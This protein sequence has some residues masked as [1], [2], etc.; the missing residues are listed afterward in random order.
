MRVTDRNAVCA[1]E[2]VNL[3]SDCKIMKQRENTENS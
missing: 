1:L 3:T 2:C